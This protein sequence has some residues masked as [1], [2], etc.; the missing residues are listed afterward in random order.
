MLFRSEIQCPNPSASEQTRKALEDTEAMANY[1][2]RVMHCYLSWLIPG[3]PWR[4]P[5]PGAPKLRTTLLD[6]H[7][8]RPEC[9]QLQLLQIPKLA[10]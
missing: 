9:K 8:P 10:D 7:P 1:G 2:L 5:E 4:R 3:L 6:R